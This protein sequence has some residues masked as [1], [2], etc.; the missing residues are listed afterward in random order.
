METT[1]LC[2]L[3]SGVT[4]AEELAAMKW[5]SGGADKLIELCDA[6]D[7][8]VAG[9]L[10]E[11]Y[12]PEYPDEETTSEVL[13][14]HTE[15][16]IYA[17]IDGRE[18]TGIAAEALAVDDYITPDDATPGRFKKWLTGNSWRKVGTVISA[19]AAAGDRFQFQA[20][21]QTDAIV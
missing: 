3:D 4:A 17:F 16:A 20:L 19:A 9:I 6:E 2:E 5:K 13:T 11:V 18:L 12:P 15:I 8:F 10:V 21:Q 14:H 7:D 1:I